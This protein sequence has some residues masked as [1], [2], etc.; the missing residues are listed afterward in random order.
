M[1]QKNYDKA[2]EASNEAVSKLYSPGAYYKKAQVYLEMNRPSEALVAIDSAI[3]AEPK[4]VDYYIEKISMLYDL[5]DYERCIQFGRLT[6]K[7]FPKEADINWY[8][9]DSYS[10]QLVHDKAASYYEAELQVNPNNDQVAAYAGWEYFY[11]QDYKM[12]QKYADIASNLYRES[13]EANSL[14]EEL[15]KT[16]LPEA[17]RVVDFVKTNYLYFNEVK[18]FEGK[19]QGFAKDKVLTPE[20]IAAYIESIRVKHDIFTYVVKGAEYELMLQEDLSSQ[21]SGSKLNEETYYIRV[22]AFTPGTGYAFGKE[23]RKIKDS[24]RKNLVIDLRGNYGGLIGSSNDI[25]DYLLPDCTTSYTIDR[26]G[27][28]ESYYSDDK[29][30]KFNK[31]LVLVDEDSASSSELLALGLK[32]YLNNVVIVGKPTFGKGVGQ[33]V[34][35]DKNKKYMIFLV[36]FYWN[37]LE[38]NIAGTRIYPDIKLK[39]NT[40]AEYEKAVYSLTK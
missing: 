8:I 9:A 15:K 24:S 3:A 31:I 12:A 30:Q 38:Q 2:L 7:L 21:V 18:D 17:E 33:N 22:G 27:Y 28:I 5:R 26:N 6:L 25:L 4:K 36:S 1:G 29:Q 34:Y 37:V 13:Y 40:Q 10:A 20:E 39:T 32:K 35:E 19:S 16:K 23:L 14:Q 11:M